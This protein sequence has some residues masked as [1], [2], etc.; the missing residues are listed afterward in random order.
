VLACGRA[1][2]KVGSELVEG[3]RS[4]QPHH[5]I[6]L[7]PGAAARGTLAREFGHGAERRRV[8]ARIIAMTMFGRQPIAARAG[9]RWGV[10]QAERGARQSMLGAGRDGGTPE[11][12][13]FEEGVAK[14]WFES[15]I[16]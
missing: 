9:G 3:A 16:V 7:R 8:H 5:A 6:A 2:F 15:D 11:K 13:R 1:R 10:A 12:R 4:A 14:K